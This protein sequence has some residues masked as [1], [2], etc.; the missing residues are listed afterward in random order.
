M[1]ET[2]QNFDLVVIGGGN[3]GT[4]LL[5][6]LFRQG[7]VSTDQVAVVELSIDRRA[8]VSGEFPE[9]LV[10]DSIPQCAAAVLAVK[11]PAIADVAAAAVTAGATRVLSIAAGITTTTLRTA[12]GEG[13]DIVRSMPNTPAMV[14]QGVTAICTDSISD[15]SVLDWA[16][17]L[18]HAVG[19]VI[20]VGEEHFDAVT[21]LTGSGPA[22]VFAFAES[23][24]AAGGAAGLPDQVLEPMVTQLLTGSAGLLAAEGNPGALR[25]AVTSPGG[26]TAAGLAVFNEM[27]LQGMVRSAVA[28]AKSRSNELGAS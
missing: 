14:G 17:E 1:A 19:M 8:V 3:M 20:R 21:G 4:A 10:T 15:P 13:I 28:A 9:V 16:D 25:E 11:P 23:L 22:Y 2:G 12:C 26:T 27:D 18:L 6:G 7:T 5:G 24:I